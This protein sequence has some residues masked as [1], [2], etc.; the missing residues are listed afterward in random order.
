MKLIDIEQSVMPVTEQAK[1]NFAKAVAQVIMSMIESGE[2][3]ELLK[4]NY[5]AG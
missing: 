1:E 4:D 2:A 5:K 3:F